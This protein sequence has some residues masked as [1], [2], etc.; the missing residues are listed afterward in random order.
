MNTFTRA[1]LMALAPGVLRN[2]RT[3]R[4]HGDDL[5]ISVNE[6]AEPD[7]RIIGQLYAFLTSLWRLSPGTNETTPKSWI[8][9]ARKKLTT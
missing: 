8:F 1:D 5:A 4:Y 9:C 2:G 7:Q 3:R 6:F